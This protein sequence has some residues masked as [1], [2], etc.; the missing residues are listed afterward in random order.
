M[1]GRTKKPRIGRPPIFDECMKRVNVML[2]DDDV[3]RAAKVGKGN[4]SHGIRV[5]LERTAREL[6]RRQNVRKS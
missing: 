1:A 2:T 6:G 3:K 5:A 4:V